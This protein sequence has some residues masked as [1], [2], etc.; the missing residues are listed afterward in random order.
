MEA[1]W[2]KIIGR[3]VDNLRLFAKKMESFGIRQNAQ[4][5][6]KFDEKFV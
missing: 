6:M 4:K 1:I 5:K 3:F 2:R